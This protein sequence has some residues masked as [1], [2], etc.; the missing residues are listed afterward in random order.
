MKAMTPNEA[1]QK[2]QNSIPS[3]VIECWNETISENMTVQMNQIISRFTLKQL[4]LKILQ[5]KESK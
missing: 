3:D 4:T 2:F 5:K 1:L